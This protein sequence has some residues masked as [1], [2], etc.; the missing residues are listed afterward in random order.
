[1]AMSSKRLIIAAAACVT[2]G[3]CSTVYSH[4]G[5]EDAG[6][7]ETVK[8]DQAIQVINPAPVYAANGAK[9]GDNGE[10]GQKAVERYRTD[11]VKQVETMETTTSSS[12][13]SSSGPR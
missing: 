3:A 1:M 7:G 11:K 10:V 13:S 12:G 4:Y 6:F 5:D 8:Y 9:P 2:L